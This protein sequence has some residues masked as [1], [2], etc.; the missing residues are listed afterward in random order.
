MNCFL[1]PTEIILQL[2]LNSINYLK[3]LMSWECHACVLSEVKTI[4]VTH[5]YY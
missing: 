2:F 4:E 1:W 5:L 3:A